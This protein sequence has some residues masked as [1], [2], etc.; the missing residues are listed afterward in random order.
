MPGAPKPE[1][2]I[3]GH[4][5]LRK[6]IR[7][8]TGSRPPGSRSNHSSFGARRH[9]LSVAQT[10][11]GSMR[12]AGTPSKD[13]TILGT[14]DAIRAQFGIFPKRRKWMAVNPTQKPV[15]CMK[16][17]IENNSSPGQAVYDP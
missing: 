4:H 14:A 13:L 8:S 15:E 7:S 10:T 17:P 9:L 12:Y 3:C 1:R 2:H 11:I 6:V 5:H 16:R